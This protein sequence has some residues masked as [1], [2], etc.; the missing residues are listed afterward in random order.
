VKKYLLIL[1][2]IFLVS[3]KKTE[4]IPFESNFR[5]SSAQPI[6]D[7]E[8][9]KIPNKF[10]GVFMN[11]DS[12]FLNIKP[13]I[14]LIEN[15]SL[16]R[17]HKT[18][19]DSLKTEFLFQNG[20]YISKE[21]KQIFDSKIIG[22]SIELSSK[23]SDTLFVLSKSQK[24]KRINGHL[25][26]SQ[27]ESFYWTSKIL[28]LDNYVLKIRQLYSEND[29]KRLDSITTIKSKEVDSATFLVEPTRP[30]F[31]KILNLKNF[32]YEQQFKKISK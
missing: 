21:N 11:S 7:S 14:I 18:E 19:K 23:N 8:L 13:N 2:L 29:R 28:T 16:F 3:C 26:I 12:T 17:F 1:G 9:S 32:G 5:F 30:E 6:N 22:D 31:S 10:L 4:E 24:A 25:V 20:K 15:Y 27:K